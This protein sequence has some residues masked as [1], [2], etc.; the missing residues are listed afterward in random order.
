MRGGLARVDRPYVAIRRP[1]L[2]FVDGRSAL[3]NPNE[4]VSYQR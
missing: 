1:Y 2:D 3:H 4:S